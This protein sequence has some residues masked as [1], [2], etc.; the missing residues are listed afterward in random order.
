M[1]RLLAKAWRLWLRFAE[2]FGNVQLTILLTLIYW[3]MLL[4]WALPYKVLSDPLALG[5]PERARWIH[6]SP[7]TDWL[8]SMRKQ[9]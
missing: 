7:G 2:V 5:N 6:R 3:T 1:L 9:G 8:D 4:F